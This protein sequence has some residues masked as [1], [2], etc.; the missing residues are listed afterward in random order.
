MYK[1]RQTH[2]LAEIKG[3]DWDWATCDEQTNVWGKEDGDLIKKEAKLIITKGLNLTLTKFE[4][5]QKLIYN[6]CKMVTFWT[7]QSNPAAIS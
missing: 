6:C 4:L 3:G 2:K 7:H 1:A 5:E